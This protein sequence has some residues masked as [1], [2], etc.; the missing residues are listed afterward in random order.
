DLREPR[1]LIT[2]GAAL[3]RRLRRNYF[4]MFL[5]LLLAWVLKISSSTLQQEGVRLDFVQSVQDVMQNA[6]LGPLPG[7]AVLLAIAAFYG[8]LTYAMV[9]ARREVG[10]LIYGE[11]HV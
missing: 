6:A 9:R 3:A 8:W 4:W 5:I 1:F 11:V 2:Q 7:W 10:E